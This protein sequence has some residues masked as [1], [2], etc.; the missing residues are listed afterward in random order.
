MTIALYTHPD[1][2]VHQPGFG[3][4]E[5]PQRLTAVL[6]ALNEAGDLDLETH[7]AEP[8]ALEDLTRVHTWRYIEAVVAAEPVQ[9][10]VLLDPDTPISA[11]SVNAAYRAAGAVAQAVRAVAAG[12]TLRAF[13]A[14]RPPGHH[15]EAERAMGFCV[16]SNVA[17]GA[18]LAREAG[19][20]RVA[21]VDFDVHHGNGT[22]SVVA[23]DPSLFFA[24]I[25][26]WPLF[27]GTGA[28]SEHGLGNVINVTVPPQAPREAWRAKFE[29]LMTPLDAFAPELILISAGFDAHARDPQAGQMLE[30]EDFAW[31]TRSIISVARARCGGRIVSSLEGGYDLEGLSRSALAHVRA[32]Q[33]E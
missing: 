8:I 14:V 32:L 6:D 3:H 21:V 16:F 20:A 30:A 12:Q 25:H 4:P 1:M 19:Y 22:Q 28:P 33:E 10:R 24:S 15:A 26:Q 2:L 23:E 29:G 11:G 17:I 9:G 13:C 27:P 18:R 7:S 31:A 5:R